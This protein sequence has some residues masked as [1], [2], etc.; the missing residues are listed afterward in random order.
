M[1]DRARFLTRL[2]VLAML[3]A[4]VLAMPGTASAAPPADGTGVIEVI[5]HTPP[6]LETE[7]DFR[8]L[9][10]GVDVRPER[11]VPFEISF[12]TEGQVFRC[13][14]LADGEYQLELADL[15]D[16]WYGSLWECAEPIGFSLFAPQPTIGSGEG[17]LD[18]WNCIVAASTPAIAGEFQPI[19]FVPETDS[20]FGYAFVGADGVDVPAVCG[21]AVDF[22]GPTTCHFVEFGVYTMRIEGVPAGYRTSS[23]C[24]EDQWWFEIGEFAEP[25]PAAEVTAE[26]PVW[27]CYGSAWAPIVVEQLPGATLT[28]SGPDGPIDGAC[29]LLADANAWHC[30]G[31]DDGTY[32]LDADSGGVPLGVT[33]VVVTE[34]TV[35]LF[36]DDP[37]GD[38][39]VGG[40]TPQECRITS[41]PPPTTTTTV[42]EVDSAAVLPV[43]GDSERATAALGGVLVAVGFACLVV[44]RRRTRAVTARR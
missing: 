30:L 20:G 44:A 23:E 25:S 10:D 2:S 4:A 8:L 34:P 35:P 24:Q 13:D 3:A 43:T 27:V 14:G 22:S 36:V 16:G 5:I 15:P 37:S 1:R 31:L 33:C 28:L 42:P 7:L 9:L 40:D 39:T 17:A 29:V 12:V 26:W 18:Y 6:A 41:A 38:V 11:C 21:P 19:G 32:H